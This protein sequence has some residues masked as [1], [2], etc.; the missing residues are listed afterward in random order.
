MKRC[1]LT[2][3]GG[4]YHEDEL[5]GTSVAPQSFAFGGVYRQPLS[6][7]Q[8]TVSTIA[9]SGPPCGACPGC[10]PVSEGVFSKVVETTG[11]N[12]G[13]GGTWTRAAAQG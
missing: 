7:A 3:L 4:H 6:A 11:I 12:V 13:G 5:A 9:G 1:A 2:F 8:T 10:E